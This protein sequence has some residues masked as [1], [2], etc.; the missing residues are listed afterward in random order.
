MGDFATGWLNTFVSTYNISY[1][2]SP[3]RAIAGYGFHAYGT[4]QWNNQLCSTDKSQ[5]YKVE[6]DPCLMNHFTNTVMA[7]I[8]WVNSNDP[9]KEVWMTELNW[10]TPEV[11]RTFTYI[12]TDWDIE[13]RRMGKMCSALGLLPISRYAWF[14]G[15]SP[16]FPNIITSSLFL[17]SPVGAVSPA[18]SSFASCP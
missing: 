4:S 11:V 9:G 14:H 2:V 16:S 6:Y 12:E 3:T 7:G 18:G 8:N 17:A 5:T 1:T 10:R 13:V 15:V